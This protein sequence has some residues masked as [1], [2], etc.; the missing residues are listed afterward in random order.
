MEK[1]KAAAEEAKVLSIYLRP[2]LN[3]LLLSLG[4]TTDQYCA[5]FG[6]AELPLAHFARPGRSHFQQAL[7]IVRDRS[8]ADHISG[9][10][11]LSPTGFPPEPA[12][13]TNNKKKPPARRA[14]ISGRPG[15]AS[16]A[17]GPVTPGKKAKALSA[18]DKKLVAQLQ[19]CLQFDPDTDYFKE[20]TTQLKI[21]IML[22]RPL[23]PR[24]ATPASSKTPHEI[25]QSLPKLHEFRLADATD[26]F[27]RQLN[28]A[29]D[30]LQSARSR[31][32]DFAPMRMVVKE[33]LKPSIVEIVRQ[34]FKQTPEAN[35]S[36]AF[37]SELRTF[38]VAHLFKTLTSRFDLAFPRPPP[39]PSQMGVAHI[40]QRLA[41]HEF[42]KTVDCEALHLKRCELDPLN[43]QWP[44]ELALF[45]NDQNSPAAMEYFAKAIAI[46]Y[47]FTAAILGFIGR[48]AHVGNREDCIVLLNM[49]D[50]RRPDDPTVTV[51]L[52]ILYQLIESSRTD[53]YVAKVSQ[54]ALRLP[55]SPTLIA[56]ESLLNVHDTFLTEIMLTRE[57]LQS[58]RTKDLLVLL[59]RFTQQ[60]REFSRAQEYLKEAIEQDREDLTL[61][62][63]LGSFQY[64]AEDYEKALS[65]FEQL[66]ALADDADP[67]VSLK[68]ALVHLRRGRYER[69]F[70]LLMHT[71][72]TC[73]TPLAW[74]ALGVCCL[75]K[76][77]L[78]EAEAA[79]SQANELDRWDA[80]TWGYCAVLCAKGARWIEGEQALCLAGRLKLRD[81]RLIAELLRLY[82]GKVKGEEAATWMNVLKQVPRG[83]CHGALEAEDAGMGPIDVDEEIAEDIPM[84]E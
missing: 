32:E 6:V 77:E 5:L 25:V 7:Q 22:T 84:D 64:A 13:D 12:P 28:V 26:E 61:W 74:A 73:E 58:G 10:P 42:H 15:T 43:P 68:L 18:K 8:Y 35:I 53:I 36:Q 56:A 30:R 47:N 24:P 27:C 83:E 80:L 59:A 40:T 75:R 38:L 23:I 19:G 45:Y 81:G 31:G 4:I 41:A 34:V 60:N 51:C 65:S 63:M 70:D 62:K 17:K 72:Q 76:G 78:D 16:K 39:V 3:D 29:I 52:L 67:S 1:W 44:F 9:A 48:L 33:N 50:E 20:S 37:I 55:R 66:L 14:A 79:L 49:L 21:E 82:E 11:L 2:D 46:D 57:Q 54:M 69:A 71:V